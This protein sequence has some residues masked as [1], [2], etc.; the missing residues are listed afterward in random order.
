MFLGVLGQV[1]KRFWKEGSRKGLWWFRKKLECSWTLVSTYGSHCWGY[2]FNLFL[3]LGVLSVDANRPEAEILVFQRLMWGN[4]AWMV[5]WSGTGCRN[6]RT[7]GTR[8]LLEH[9]ETSQRS[10]G[11]SGS[12]WKFWRLR[13]DSYLQWSSEWFSQCYKHFPMLKR[14][15]PRFFSIPKRELNDLHDCCVEAVVEKKVIQTSRKV[16]RSSC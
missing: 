1:L 14:L 7:W 2:I 12:G 3:I 13:G 9:L 4:W 16:Q 6:G 10:S 15:K 8:C 5:R 11:R